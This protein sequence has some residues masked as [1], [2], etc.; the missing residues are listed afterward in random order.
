MEQA[1]FGLKMMSD[2]HVTESEKSTEVKVIVVNQVKERELSEV[3]MVEESEVSEMNEEKGE[4]VKRQRDA[5]ETVD[6]ECGL[7]KSIL[8]SDIEVEVRQSNKLTDDLGEVE[9]G[10]THNLGVVEVGLTMMTDNGTNDCRHGKGRLEVAR[11]EGEGG[12]TDT[13]QSLC[14]IILSLTCNDDN[15]IK[16]TTGPSSRLI[17]DRR[18][19]VDSWRARWALDDPT[20]LTPASTSLTSFTAVS[21]APNSSHL[22]YVNEPHRLASIVAELPV[23]AQRKLEIAHHLWRVRLIEA[24]AAIGQALYLAM[25]GGR[26]HGQLMKLIEDKDNLCARLER[27][28][29]KIKAQGDWCISAINQMATPRRSSKPPRM[30]LLFDDLTQSR[31]PPRRRAS[32]H[33]TSSPL[34]TL[35]QA[36]P[37]AWTECIATFP[38]DF[39]AVH[40]L[41]QLAIEVWDVEQHGISRESRRGFSLFCSLVDYVFEHYSPD[42]DVGMRLQRLRSLIA[43]LA[44]LR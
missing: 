10:V 6:Y 8:K 19:H 21:P 32:H 14:D 25:E 7:N 41:E 1:G 3:N 11:S 33:F 27:L 12:D 20:P 28:G 36:A 29:E 15:V 9:V 34:D 4:D 16:T 2:I 13:A 44:T 38:L 39:I 24:K 30:F 17:T 26:L 5:D 37:T 40:M 35:T 31:P 22:T 43:H 42:S 23:I 18:A